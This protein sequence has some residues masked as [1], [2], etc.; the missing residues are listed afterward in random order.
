MDEKAAP[1]RVP[2]RAAY[3]G[4]SSTPPPRCFDRR[5]RARSRRVSSERL[6]LPAVRARASMRDSRP[7]SDLSASTCRPVGCL[8]MA[9]RAA[10]V[11]SAPESR[12]SVAA[13]AACA[14]AAAA[15][16]CRSR[17]NGLAHPPEGTVFARADRMPDGP[18]PINSNASRLRPRP[19]L[20]SA[21]RARP[22]KCSNGL[23]AAAICL[24]GNSASAQRSCSTATA[25]RPIRVPNEAGLSADGLLIRRTCARP[26]C[27]SET[28]APPTI[29]Q[30]CR[31]SR[32]AVE[33]TPR[34]FSRPRRISPM[35][36]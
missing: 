28:S 15:L 5:A 11:N 35:A 1:G 33:D 2:G 14:S 36:A 25:H 32:D 21:S 6:V 13:G 8:R 19:S 22:R 4:P 12:A 20:S 29:L 10:A 23:A 27:P 16:C 18:C 3:C 17:S 31:R 34:E 9:W 7:A 24:S 30:R 26:I